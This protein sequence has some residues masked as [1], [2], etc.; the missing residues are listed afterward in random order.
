MLCSMG[1]YKNNNICTFWEQIPYT[2]QTITAEKTTQLFVTT[3]KSPV[4]E[5]T[6]ED[7]P[8]CYHYKSPVTTEE[9]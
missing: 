1:Q 9:F 5:I 4:T 3:E 6:N 8:I 2:R 7:S